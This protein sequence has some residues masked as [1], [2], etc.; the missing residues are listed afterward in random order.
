MSLTT[1]TFVAAAPPMV[2]E[3]APVRWAP[4]IVIG[5][6]PPVGPVDGLTDATVGAATADDTETF[7]FCD[8]APQ[9]A[10]MPPQFE[11]CMSG[12]TV[13]PVTQEHTFWL[14]ATVS[15]RPAP[16]N[17]VAQEELLH[18]RLLGEPAR[19]AS[20]ICCALIGSL[21]VRP[22]GS[23]EPLMVI[24][25]TPELGSDARNEDQLVD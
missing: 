2:T 12:R 22:T 7:K 11:F 6:P 3:L 14:F 4:V 19:S 21:Q 5:V 18:W 10:P 1:V 25:V 15:S 24:E 17:P 20:A 9:V 23:S 8:G 16:Q 13:Y